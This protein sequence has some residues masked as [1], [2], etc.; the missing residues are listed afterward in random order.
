M[1]LDLNIYI[2]IFNIKDTNIF[3][4]YDLKIIKEKYELIYKKKL[5]IYIFI[6]K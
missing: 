6:Y 4:E 5:T 1:C 3:D 2:Y